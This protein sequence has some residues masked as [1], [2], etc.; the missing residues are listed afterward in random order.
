MQRGPVKL[1]PF[2]P[3]LREALDSLRVVAAPAALIWPTLLSVLA[4]GLEGVALFVILGGF[5]ANVSVGNSV[6][7]YSVATLAGALVPVPGGLGVAETLIQ[8]QLSVLGGVAQGAATASML[9]VRF[10]TLWWGV[11]VGF[12]ALFILR[13]RFPNELKDSP[14]ALAEAPVK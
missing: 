7:F 1:R 3:K 2:A 5:D 13:V 6:F 9:L 8:Q 11:L 12:I 14:T 10:A 4:W